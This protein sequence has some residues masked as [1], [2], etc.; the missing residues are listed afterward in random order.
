MSGASRFSENVVASPNKF[1]VVM[2][3][4]A[5][6]A[7][8]A[9]IAYDLD[10]CGANLDPPTVKERSSLFDD[11]APLPDSVESKQKVS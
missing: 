1:K 11:A 9:S 4:E 10:S 3:M 8:D 5:L 2:N 7:L 6:G